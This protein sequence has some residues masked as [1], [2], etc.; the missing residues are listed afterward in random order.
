M[1]RWFLL[2]SKNTASELFNRINVIR[3]KL[4]DIWAPEK[5]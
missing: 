4:T 2:D 5:K 1:K 3:G